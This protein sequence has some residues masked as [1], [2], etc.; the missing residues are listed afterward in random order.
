[1]ANK[2]KMQ[3]RTH[4]S[5]KSNQQTPQLTQ[6]TFYL[7]WAIVEACPP[8]A[9]LPQIQGRCRSAIVNYAGWDLTQ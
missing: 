2:I 5:L 3:E 8:L 6:F 7:G 9:W 1:M 4:L